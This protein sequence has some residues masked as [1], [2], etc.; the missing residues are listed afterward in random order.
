MK[1]IAF[2]FLLIIATSFAA[3][4]EAQAQ[5]AMCSINAEQGTKNGNTQGK[6]IND[7]V[8]Y[9]MAMPYLLIASIGVLWYMKY[10]KR[11]L[12]HD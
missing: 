11:T 1:Q 5:C 9:L 10:R 4:P 6:G 8:L 7:G 12:R 3:I 2:I